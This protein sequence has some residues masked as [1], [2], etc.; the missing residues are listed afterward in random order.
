M[1]RYRRRKHSDVWHFHQLCQ[2]WQVVAGVEFIEKRL[3]RP[4]SGE[5][6]NECLAKARAEAKLLATA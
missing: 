4:K 2:H 1:V 5:L 3:S 6:C